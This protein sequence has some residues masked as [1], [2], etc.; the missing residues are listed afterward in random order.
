MAEKLI[1]GLCGILCAAPFLIL[2]FWGRNS[3]TPLNFW[4]G[5]TSLSEKI[6]DVAAYNRAMSRMYLFYGGVLLLTAC[7]AIWSVAVVVSLWV[8]EFTLGLYLLYRCYKKLLVKYGR[9]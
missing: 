3:K 8:A 6:C 4:S 1:V 2:G 5:D 7:F 9:F